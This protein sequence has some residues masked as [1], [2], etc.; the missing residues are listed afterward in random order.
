MAGE[1]SRKDTLRYRKHLSAADPSKCDFCAIQKGDKQLVE[2]T[3]YFK[4][5]HN[6]FPYSLW[7][8]LDVVDHLM[9]T[10]IR[11]TDTLGNMS[12]EEKVEYV[13]MLEKYE[14]QGYNIYAR[15]PDSKSKSIVHQ[16][17]HFIKTTGRPKKIVISFDHPYFRFMR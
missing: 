9:L 3:K 10:P 13:N 17:T 2:Q 15:T 12:P 8:G 6:R 5:L 16:H 14:A 7:D 4:V 11:H 1:R